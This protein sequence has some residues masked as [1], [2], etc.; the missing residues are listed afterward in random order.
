VVVAG[1]EVAP[2]PDTLNQLT[3][4]Q[5]RAVA[6][7]LP[8]VTPTG[9]K[10]DLV[11]KIAPAVAARAEQQQATTDQPADQPPSRH[12]RTPPPRPLRRPR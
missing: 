11:S 5:L 7:E 9:R 3:M 1:I 6:T 12:R 8:G 10:A 2:D 4:D